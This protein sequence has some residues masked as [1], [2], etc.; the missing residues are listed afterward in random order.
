[1]PESITLYLVG[2]WLAVGFVVSVGWSLG[3]AL[4]ARLLR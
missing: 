1:M 3:A 2:V 4:V